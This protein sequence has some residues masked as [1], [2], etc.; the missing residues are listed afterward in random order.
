MVAAMEGSLMVL[1]PSAMLSLTD[2]APISSLAAGI[3]TTL[4][5]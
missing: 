3:R 2:D 5:V 1:R 4:Y